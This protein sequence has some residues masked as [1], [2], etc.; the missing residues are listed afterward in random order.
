MVFR[1]ETVLVSSAFHDEL[2][3]DPPPH[4][5]RILVAEDLTHSDRLTAEVWLEQVMG[6]LKM[7]C[8]LGERIRD[9][10]RGDTV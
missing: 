5:V 3:P 2:E 1:Q 6:F 8:E 10:L 7:R 4:Q 9:K